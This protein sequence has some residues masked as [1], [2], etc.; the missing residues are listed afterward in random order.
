MI[1]PK[2]TLPPPKPSIVVYVL[3]AVLAVGFVFLFLAAR[4]AFGM[5]MSGSQAVAGAV[6][7][8][9]GMLISAISYSRDKNKYAVIELIIS[10]AVSGTYN[11]I[12]V[13]NAGA[14]Y[15]IQNQWQLVTLALGP[16]TAMLFASLMMGNLIN[17]HE[18]NIRSY[19]QGKQAFYIDEQKRQE[20]RADR[21]KTKELKAKNGLNGNF[22]KVSGNGK[23]IPEGVAIRPEVFR[24]LPEKPSWPDLNAE[25]V[26]ALVGL[27]ASKITKI[28][29]MIIDRTARNWANRASKQFI[30]KEG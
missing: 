11:Y 26:S 13:S 20:K 21:M 6:L 28:F 17:K 8:E 7:I 15:G 4:E 14:E 5:V 23:A 25:Q 9:A 3:S 1:D 24:G 19:E 30:E 27:S 18:E 16:L 12:Q 10:L 2:Y 22:R 29:P